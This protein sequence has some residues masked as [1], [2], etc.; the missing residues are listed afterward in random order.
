MNFGCDLLCGVNFSCHDLPL[1]FLVLWT[2]PH[3]NQFHLRWTPLRLVS[4][5]VIF[6]GRQFRLRLSPMR[7]Y[8][9]RN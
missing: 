8:F 9:G 3:H 6:R 7:I 2:I 1:H 4:V 5:A